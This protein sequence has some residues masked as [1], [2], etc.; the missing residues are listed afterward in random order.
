MAR[1][2][3]SIDKNRADS[4]A[5]AKREAELIRG[6]A[7]LEAEKILRQ[8]EMRRKI[9][10]EDIR[11]LEVLYGKLRSRLKIILETINDLLKT[12][13]ELK[14]EI[15]ARAKRQTSPAPK[16]AAPAQPAPQQGLFDASTQSEPSTTGDDGP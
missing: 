9:L 3:S 5:L 12:P 4:E 16:T 15:P 10:A 6:Q 1:A 11:S 14:A 8:A 7:K 2:M 13:E